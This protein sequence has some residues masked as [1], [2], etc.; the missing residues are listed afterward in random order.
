MNKRRF[1]IALLLNI[2]IPG[3]GHF[4]LGKAAHWFIAAATAIASLWFLGLT[5]SITTPAGY[6]GAF[7]VLIA[8]Q[9]YVLVDVWRI[10]RRQV[11]EPL[12][13]NRWYL[14]VP[15]AA[16]VLVAGLYIPEFKTEV[17]GCQAFRVPGEAMQPTIM[18]GE[19]IL[20]DT[21]TYRGK[22]TGVGDVVVV[23]APASSILYVRR[24]VGVTG[25]AGIR[26]S[27]D[28]PAAGPDDRVY[29][30]KDVR[31]KVTFIYYSPDFRR[32]GSR[33]R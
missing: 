22:S 32:I 19:H 26:V 14:Y 2:L 8:F 13:Y 17:L 3:L 6:A 33:V 10:T 28:N 30:A 31:G 4:Y 21:K 1:T 20:V 7:V 18:A 12:W 24:V 5:R 25:P 11:C 29:S 15:F 27:K 9:A 23:R 16:S